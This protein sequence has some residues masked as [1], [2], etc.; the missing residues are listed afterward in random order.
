MG[1]CPKSRDLRNGAAAQVAVV[2]HDFCVVRARVNLRTAVRLAV[3]LA[4]V[5]AGVA[6]AGACG[7]SG[8]GQCLNPQPF[9]PFCGGGGPQPLPPNDWPRPEDAGKADGEGGPDAGAAADG[10][11]GAASC[12]PGATVAPRAPSSHRASGSSCPSDR[13]PVSPDASMCTAPADSGLCI[14]V[15]DSDC[16]A[17]QNG[18]CTRNIR[19]TV[20]GFGIPADYSEGTSCSYDECF[21]DSQ[22]SD[23]GAPCTCRASGILTEANVCVSGGNC[24]VDSECG[25]GG[26][27]SPSALEGCSCWGPCAPDAGGG[28]AESIDGG[29]PVAVACV[30]SIPCS[31]YFCHTRCDQCV[32]DSD[33]QSGHCSYDT[34]SGRWE[35]LQPACPL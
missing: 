19:P 2:W 9:P 13:G 12:G 7:S 1:G 31:G 5:C 6:L 26:Y 27:C 24:A 15:A 33:C 3:Y 30:C 8:G 35:C 28:C 18:R 14:C 20:G 29:P 23:G 17:G 32:E 34:M 16:T 10:S 4:A 22:C 11:P 25:P 21:S